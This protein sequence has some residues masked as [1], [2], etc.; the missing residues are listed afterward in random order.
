[1]NESILTRFFDRAER[2]GDRVALRTVKTASGG[3]DVAITWAQWRDSSL[4]FAAAILQSSAERSE[5]VAILAGNT[6]AW[7]IADI[8]TL[9]SG[10]TS[11]GI[12]PTSA[13]VQIEKMLLDSGAGLVVSDDSQQLLSILEMQPRL[14]NLKAIISLVDDAVPGTIRWTDWLETG[15]RAL[16]EYAELGVFIESRARGINRTAPAI[17][18]YTSGSTGEPKGAILS[19]GC[20]DASA[21]SIQDALG[22]LESDTTVS[23]LTFSHAAER[24]FGHYVR[25]LCG[26]EAAFVEDHSRLWDVATVYQPTVFGGLPRY[27]EKLY[28]R[29]TENSNDAG[30]SPLGSRLRIATSGGAVLPLELTESLYQ[31]GVTVL[32]AYGLTE[33]LCVAMNRPGDFVFDSVGRAMRGTEM[34][35]AADGEVLV[36]R[37]E[38]TFSGYRNLP[39][40]TRASFTEDGDWVRTGDLGTVDEHGRLR[41]TGRKKELLALSN[42]KMVAPL[43]IEMR[44]AR[45]P[46]IGQAVLH[47][48]GRKFVSALIA[49]RP[50]V[51]ARWAAEKGLPELDG[52][53]V[54]HPLVIAEIQNAVD[55]VNATL[56]RAEGI[57]RFVLIDRELSVAANELTPTLKVRRS[58]VLEKYSAQLDALYG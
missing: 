15:K 37:S 46:W 26:M 9:M 22:L 7:P 45:H 24:I 21:A 8:G 3:A 32:G 5:S 51:V 36:R 30:S 39:D 2:Q 52:A 35:I 53:L 20:I 48:E 25:I 50:E 13:P 17:I 54:S 10:K 16:A 6:F 38:L 12:Y 31:R 29:M 56:S 33:H 19:H 1:M 23:F 34:S 4:Q 27:Y 43:P 11:V 57:R 47:A 40:E 58:T 14:P 49:L 55:E 41:I 28:K 18:I 44:L 42:G